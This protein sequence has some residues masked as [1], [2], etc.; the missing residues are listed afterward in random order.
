MEIKITRREFLKL[1][2]LTS[3]RY[4]I[5]KNIPAESNQ[6]LITDQMNVL[7]VVFDAWS[8]TNIS[9]FGY[10][11]K[12]TPH[13]DQLADRAV[14][15]H[16]HFAGGHYTAPGTATLLT[17]TQPWTHRAFNYYPVL[18]EAQ[19]NIFHAFHPYHRFAYTHNPLADHQLKQFTG[20]LENFESWEKLYFEY[21]QLIHLLK[22]D[23]DIA[24]VSWDRA[25]ESQDDGYSYSLI[26]SRLYG[27]R[28]AK[29]LANYERLFPRGVPNSENQ[30]YF[31]LEDG[32]D[33]LSDLAGSVPQPF[34]GY[35][36]YFPPHAPFL[37]R[38]DFM[39]VFL[40]DGYS[41]PE[42]P[43]HIFTN[44]SANY[45]ERQRRWYDE[46]IL[47]VDAE[48]NRLYQQL[49][50]SGILENTWIV[51]TSDHGEMFERDIW[52]HSEPVFYQPIVHIPLV[53][54]PPG[55]KERI[56]VYDQT[57]AVDVLPTLLKVTGQDVP[58]WVEGLV[59][60]PF[61]TTASKEARDIITIQVG[62]VEDGE[63]K[64]ASTM[65]VRDNYKALW[66]FGYDQIQ[67]GQEIIE[68][69]DIDADPEELQDLY[70]L[71]KELADELVGVL[72]SKIAQLNQTY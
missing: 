58:S 59:L 22:Q 71:Q 20:D 23:Q 27:R 51:L 13:L 11:R 47:Y 21:N 29:R 52:G 28:K 12:T 32:I 46:F 38:R 31:T 69:Y 72:R 40:N 42:K 63:I 65:C 17:G 15:Y 8:A 7:I 48:F 54:F 5:P 35:Y 26:L 30:A 6:D 55:Q 68:L 19:H 56:D 60:P 57:S 3:L 67:A 10:P 36:H 70:P 49:E 64:V 39:N 16:N 33:W 18:D 41:P 2:A 25:M 43:A 45:A 34:L 24:R 1:M 14:V 66:L 50:H 9:L 62:K 53:I 44:S 61:D 37:T 4:A